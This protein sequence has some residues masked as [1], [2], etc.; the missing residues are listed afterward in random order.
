MLRCVSTSLRPR[1]RTPPRDLRAWPLVALAVAVVIVVVAALSAGWFRRDDE[2]ISW[3]AT[4]AAAIGWGDQFAG[5]PDADERYEIGSITKLVTALVVLDRVSLPAGS[6]GPTLL[7]TEDD[8]QFAKQDPGPTESLI[9]AT[10]GEALSLRTMLEYTL[11]ASSNTHARALSLRILG[12]ETTYLTAARA[13]LDERGLQE[14]S[15]ADANGISPDNT[16]TA[17]ALLELGRFADADPTIREIVNQPGVRTP[18]G[19]WVDAVNG[20]LGTQGIDGLKTGHPADG[21]YAMIFSADREG[22]RV[23][24]AVL[25]SP[26]LA[27]RAT[28]V[29]RLLAQT[30]GESG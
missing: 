19:Q 20:L 7:L 11:I 6:L 1:P 3:P 12:D 27:Q 2:Q 30:G 28:D 15:I 13:W 14:I 10:T 29:I 23:I 25:G 8:A 21:T 4:G 24:G 18:T 26:S 9:P 17:T 16:A 5:S 22:T